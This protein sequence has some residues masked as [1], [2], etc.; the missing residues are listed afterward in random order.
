MRKLTKKLAMLLSFILIF[1]MTMCNMVW[2]ISA[3][4]GTGEEAD[5]VESE[6]TIDGSGEEP[7]GE[8]AEEPD[9][10]PAADEEI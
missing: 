6:E 2:R 4:D 10:E 5:P 7:S 9:G 8:A 3:E 1:G